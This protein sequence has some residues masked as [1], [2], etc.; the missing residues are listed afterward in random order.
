MD[1]RAFITV[2]G[3]SI[4]TAPLVAKA[5]QAAKV[6]RIGFVSAGA[7]PIA[8]AREAFVL[9]LRELG[10]I[11]GQNVVIEW[12]FAEGNLDRLP[13]LVADLLRLNVDVIVTVDTPAAKVAKE[14]T[15][16][17]PIVIQV[18]DPVRTGLVSSL[19]RPGGNVTGLDV[20]NTEL[21]R[22]GLQLL[23]EVVPKASHI[24]FLGRPDNPVLVSSWPPHH[25]SASRCVA[26][27]YETRPTSTGLCPHG[28]GARWWIGGSW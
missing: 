11:E 21:R 15:K 1:R 3:G 22:K 2:V 26:S 9:R 28:P 10:W 16:T 7:G 14:A 24:G 17:V 13:A 8:P 27:T 5:Q 18:S 20:A 25:H 19:A 12:R 6:W 23:R 4:F